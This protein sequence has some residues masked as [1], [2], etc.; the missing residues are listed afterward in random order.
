MTDFD[1]EDLL[2]EAGGD[3]AA[4]VTLPEDLEASSDLRPTRV[5]HKVAAELEMC[6]RA[7]KNSSGQTGE[8]DFPNA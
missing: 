5:A 4:R 1:P 6:A 2:D 8:R 3:R 7:L